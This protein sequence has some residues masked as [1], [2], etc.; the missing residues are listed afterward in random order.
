MSLFNVFVPTKTEKILTIPTDVDKLIRSEELLKLLILGGYQNGSVKNTLS[1]Y[2]DGRY[3]YEYNDAPLIKIK[4]GEICYFSPAGY[5][6]IPCSNEKLNDIKSELIDIYSDCTFA[7][8]CRFQMYPY[9]SIHPSFL[10]THTINEDF[11]KTQCI[12]IRRVIQDSSHPE[13]VA[14]PRNGGEGMV[15]Q[16]VVYAPNPGKWIPTV[17]K[18]ETRNDFMGVIAVLWV[19]HY[20]GGKGLQVREVNNNN[21]KQTTFQK[22]KIKSFTFDFGNGIAFTFDTEKDEIEWY[23]VIYGLEITN[24]PRGLNE[25]FRFVYKNSEISR[26]FSFTD[27]V[28]TPISLAKTAMDL[29]NTTVPRKEI[30][31][32][33]TVYRIGNDDEVLDALGIESNG[34]ERHTYRQ[35]G[36]GGNI[37]G[38]QI[39][40]DMLKYMI[41]RLFFA[42]YKFKNPTN[43]NPV[44]LIPRMARLITR[45]ETNDEVG[46]LADNDFY[47]IVVG[48]FEKTTDVAQTGYQIPKQFGK[49]LIAFNNIDK[50]MYK[51]GY[52]PVSIFKIYLHFK[53]YF[54]KLIK[55]KSVDEF[56]ANVQDVPNI[57]LKDMYFDPGE[58]NKIVDI[59]TLIEYGCCCLFEFKHIPEY[60]DLHK[61]I[62]VVR[63]IV[64][65]VPLSDDSKD[66]LKSVLQYVSQINTNDDA[67]KKYEM[68]IDYN[69]IS[70]FIKILNNI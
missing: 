35:F 64:R 19:I 15:Q 59:D 10:P 49:G 66:F 43:M 68:D 57:D 13:L 2:K 11:F 28:T 56:R 24:K 33:T 69:D 21:I 50:R 42:R 44:Y 67:N 6:N 27:N 7:H 62:R 4:Y 30:Q 41:L 36:M 20:L 48:L 1:H 5:V 54:E 55:S 25:L 65:H 61:F 23:P 52:Y 53:N 14:F 51:Y 58:Y 9:L 70:G 16:F 26:N 3:M 34:G 40:N 37:T 39:T 17:C 12:Q 63:N 31:R 46:G 22:D 18:M 47:A 38:D 8:I 45:R 29:C 60:N 32:D